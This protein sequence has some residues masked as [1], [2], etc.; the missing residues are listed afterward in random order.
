M[1]TGAGKSLCYQLPAL[2]RDDLTVVVSPLVSLMQDQVEGLERVAPGRAALVNAQ[3]DAGANRAVMAR[4]AAGEVRLLYIAPERFSSPGFAEALRAAARRAV[5]RRRGALRLAVGPRLP[6]GLLPPRRR[7]ALA[8]R[9]GARRLDRHRDAAGRRR[10]R[11]APGAARAGAGHHRLRSPEPVLRR[12]AVP[13]RGRQARADRRRA[14]ATTARARP[15]STRARARRPRTWP[16]P[17]RARSGPRCWP[18]TPASGARSAPT[19]SGASWT[20]RSRWWWPPTPSAWASTSPTCGPSR[21][22]RC[23]ARSRPT[24]R[25]PGAR[26]ATGS[27]RARCSSPRAAT[28]ACTCSSS[29]APRSTTRRSRRWPA[30]CCA[31]RSTAATTCRCRPPA[32]PSPSGCA[33]SSATSRGRAWCARRRR[34]SIGCAGASSA[35][36][37]GRAR[38]DVPVVGG[39]CAARPLAPVPRGVGLRRGRRVPARG[40]PAPLRRSRAAAG[41]GAVLRRLRARARACGAGAASRRRRS[42]GRR[43]RRGHRRRGHRRRALGRAHANGRDPA[44]RAL[45]GRA[46]ERLRRAARLRRRSPTCA[47]TRCWRASTSCSTRGGWSRPAAPTPSCGSGRVA[48]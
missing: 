22:P 35:A 21:T 18:T 2:M 44:R 46:Q 40:D 26:A 36:F 16:A 27:R 12:R 15:S 13:R 1:P 42:G 7:G 11:R 41:R 39:R 43:P 19:P 24:T 9:A 33:P 31:P 8:G 14:G 17:W 32:I 45:A 4:A 37:D 38:A 34:P 3:Q 48:A 6:P 10:H 5:R 20:A 29:S 47:P 28:R 23:R 30:R 25:R